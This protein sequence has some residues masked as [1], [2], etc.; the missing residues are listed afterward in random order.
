[1]ALSR[2]MEFHADAVSASVSG[3]LPLITS[4]RRLE[5]ANICYERVLS[6]YN[7][8]FSKN[9]KAV[10]MY[11]DHAEVMKHFALSHD[12]KIENGI[13]EVTASSF[14]RFNRSR[15][16]VKD[17]WASH[18]DTDDRE[19]H[20]RKLNITADI[21]NDSAWVLFSNAEQLQKEMTGHLYAAA[22]FK[23]DPTPADHEAF[24][25]KYY[26]AF[27]H[28]SFDKRYKGFYDSRDIEPFEID[29]VPAFTHGDK[30]Q[31]S[32]IL[33]DEALALPHQISGLGADLKLLPQIEQSREIKTFDFDGIK[34]HR[35]EIDSLKKKLEKEL[36]DAKS[37]LQEVDRKLFSWFRNLA[38]Q[39]G[40]EQKLI[41]QYLKLF[42]AKKSVAQDS[43]KFDSIMREVSQL[44]NQSVSIDAA[45]AITN[46]LKREEIYIKE[47]IRE[48]LNDERYSK[49][50]QEEDKDKLLRYIEKQREY[51][52]SPNFNQEALTVFNEA[53]RV[54]SDILGEK[55]FN[56]LKDVLELQLSYL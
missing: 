2:E 24:K 37:A 49:C 36:S 22:K 48:I 21:I 28:Y 12:L 8:W 20:L 18:P 5:V 46:N 19:A 27:N 17:Q 41:D 31:F 47:R 30:N 26:E 7:N 34:Y 51:F 35:D 43:A 3:S 38:A 50:Y 40:Q 42:E 4:L 13:V 11:P 23:S 52:V 39:Q 33:N 15:I 55:K 56:A 53:M 6:Q 14:K 10:N 29:S 45:T 32:E 25:T 1:M 44:Y 9:Y 54:Y 16:V